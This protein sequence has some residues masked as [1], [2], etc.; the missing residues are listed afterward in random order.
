[1]RTEV[2]S[3]PFGETPREKIRERAA[4]GFV[5]RDWLEPSNDLELGPDHLLT[6]LD[7]LLLVARGQA[8]V[9]S[10]TAEGTLRIAILA[11]LGIQEV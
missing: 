6:V 10:G 5:V 3:Y 9:S 7:A 8:M 4:N 11:A 2:K 1:M